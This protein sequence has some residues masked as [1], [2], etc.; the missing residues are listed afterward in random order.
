M[1][2][3]EGW[4]MSGSSPAPGTKHDLHLDVTRCYCRGFNRWPRAVGRE[5]GKHGA[6]KPGLHLLELTLFI[7]CQPVLLI[8]LLEIILDLQGSCKDKAEN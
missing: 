4:V 6:N 7:F 1:P 3:G 5:L 2:S 8:V